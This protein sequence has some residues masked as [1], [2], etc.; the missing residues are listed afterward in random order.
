MRRFLSS[1]LFPFFRTPQSLCAWM[2]AAAAVGESPYIVA[3]TGEG[4]GEGNICR[5]DTARAV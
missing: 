1:S 5:K 3:D 2:V 4:E